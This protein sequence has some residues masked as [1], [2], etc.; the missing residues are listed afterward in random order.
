MRK[1]WKKAK[2]GYWRKGNMRVERDGSQWCAMIAPGGNYAFLYTM[3]PYK[4]VHKAIEAAEKED[5]A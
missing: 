2:A 5:R 3:G 1:G 4:T